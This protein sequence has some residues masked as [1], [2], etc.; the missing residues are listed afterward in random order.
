MILVATLALIGCANRGVGPQGGPKDS[1]PPVPV[2]SE[3]EN[4]TVNFH[5]KRIE[6]TFNEYIQL[7]DL[8]NNLL[9][10]PP[11]QNPPDVKARGKRLIV[12]FQ[13]TLRDST[14]YTIDFGAAVCDYTEKNPL[15]GFSFSF[16]TGESIDTLELHG[17]VINAEDLN[18]V[19]N[20]LVGIHSNLHDSALTKEP[21][22][23]IAKTD[24]MGHFRIGNIHPG[25]YRLYALDDISRDYRFTLGEGLAFYDSIITVKA[26]QL[27]DSG[28]VSI[29]P[30]LRFFHEK[31][32]RLYLQR[33]QRDEQHAFRMLFSAPVDSLPMLR[34]LRPSEYDS[35]RSDSAWFDF[36]PYIITQPSDK[37]DTVTY[38]ISDS[39]VISMDTL[40]LETRY[41]RTDSLYQLEW[42]TDTLMAVWR[43]PKLNA[44]ARDAQERKNRN[45]RVE[46]HSN[47]R[48]DFELYDTLTLYSAT[49]LRTI[50]ADSLH[51]YQRVDSVLKSVA[52]TIEPHDSV[53]MSFRLLA[54]LQPGE[55]YELVV[56]SGAVQDIYGI[57]NYSYEFKAQLK[58]PE[59]YSTLRVKLTPFNPQA[60]IQVLNNKDQVLRELQAMP[61]GAFFQFLKPD[62]YYLRLYLDTNNDG[63]WTTGEWSEHRQ[64]EEVYYYHEKIQTKS[65][66]DFEEEW[67][68]TAMPQLKGKPAEL[69][70]STAKKK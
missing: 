61:E 6:V 38:W 64:P 43:A 17:A 51:L 55:Q 36:M 5:G 68:Y 56:D 47:A 25:R 40:L 39:L 48:K 57:A 9:M 60:R 24:S 1:I 53:T 14:T 13:D 41:R 52:F 44:K 29:G 66:W 70:K 4:G 49:P 46:L 33:L 35:T 18:S 65:N 2:Q 23:R 32:A 3:P 34:A 31:K 19:G 69:K 67:D 8:G 63:E 37:R 21:F 7:S 20:I 16:S 28:N 11:Q 12:Q 58:K 15:P 27:Q 59:D 22:L 30:S 42:Y 45:R 26:Q 62:T 10:S 54:A 50:Y